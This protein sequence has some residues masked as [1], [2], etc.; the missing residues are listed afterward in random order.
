MKK[1]EIKPTILVLSILGI[2]I[3]SGFVVSLI[4]KELFVM[5]LFGFLLF[6]WLIGFAGI[7]DEA[8]EVRGV[9]FDKPVIRR[10]DADGVYRE[11]RLQLIQATEEMS[12][13]FEVI[14]NIYENPE[15]LK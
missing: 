13:D 1:E 12:I 3:A 6:L 10:I 8:N 5:I 2:V 15:L 11:E 4:F 7:L 9:E 14:G